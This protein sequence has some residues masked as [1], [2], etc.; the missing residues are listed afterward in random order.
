MG[1]EI[2]AKMKVNDFEPVRE[3]LTRS[4]ATRVGVVLETNA[5]YDTPTRELLSTDRGLRLRTNRDL[6]S[7]EQS[8]VITVK[9]AQQKSEVK[10]REE[11]E[12]SVEDGQKADDVLRALGFRPTLSFEKRRET[13]KLGGCKVE[14]DELPILGRFVEIE[15]PDEATVLRAREQLGLSDLPPIRTGYVSMLA[16]HLQEQKDSRTAIT[17]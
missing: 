16:R 15:G 2:E 14:L 17:F 6:A 13:W 1:L 8:Y 10:S 3:S 12:V 11:A 5:F 9:G 4:G 7:G